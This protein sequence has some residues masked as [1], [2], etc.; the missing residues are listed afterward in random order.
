MISAENIAV[1][2]VKMPNIKNIKISNN[3]PNIFLKFFKKIGILRSLNFK[4]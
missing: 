4:R 3:I 1:T 2:N